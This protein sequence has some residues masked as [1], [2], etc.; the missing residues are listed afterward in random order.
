MVTLFLTFLFGCF[1]FYYL[2]LV[3]TQNSLVIR[4]Q[5]WNHTLALA[6]A[7]VE[8]ALAQ[9]NP[10]AAQKVIDRTANGWG[11][12][13]GG[14][15]GP[16]TR[17]V[18]GGSYSVVYTDD[19]FPII[20]ATGHVAVASI[21]A[22]LTRTLR[23]GT[24][25]APLFTVPMAAKENIDF[26]GNG[27]FTDSF[28]S[29]LPSLSQNGRY[30]VPYDPAK[31]ST[32]GTIASEWGVVNVNGGT[33]HG[34]LLLGPTATDSVKNGG[35]VTGSVYHDFNY[36]F[37]DVTLPLDANWLPPQIVQMN[38]TVDG[39][40]YKYAFFN[41]GDFLITGLSGS[42]YVGTN[43]N[44]R[45][46]LI[47]DA[48]PTNMRVAGL[49]AAAGT[50]EIYMT[51]ANFTLQGQNTVDGGV[52]A[53]FSYFGLPSNTMV[54]LGGNASFTGTIYAP[55]A[56][57]KLNGGGTDIY[58]FV[59]ACVAA[60]VIMNGHYSFHFDEALLKDGKKLGY[61]AVS[62]REI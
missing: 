2:K 18:T 33:V 50:L 16:M 38:K 48:A 26:K 8:E 29:S 3:S 51:G 41:S 47:G 14:L 9:L 36:D 28:N 56:F 12:A 34:D 49:G 27:V 11:T 24:T 55:E 58:D 21:P 37:W 19:P 45:L 52:A 10:G 59:G 60:R 7:G 13:A 54:T 46:K 17:N 6:E 57:L 5:A 32:N 61:V 4:A 30:P 53:N 62:W 15:Y 42:V 25:N 40:P 39:V 35:V 1:L 22:T 43:A 31:T 20:Y 23:V 44:V